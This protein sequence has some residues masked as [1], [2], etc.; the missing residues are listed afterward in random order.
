MADVRW[1]CV[2]CGASAGVDPRYLAAARAV[3]EG[4]AARG[5]GLVY[6]GGR[7]GLMG[8]VAEAALAAG[9]DVVG[10][11]P[12]GLVIRLLEASRSDRVS[13]MTLS[14]A[15]NWVSSVATFA[16]PSRIITRIA[17]SVGSAT[18]RSGLPSAREPDCTAASTS[19]RLASWITRR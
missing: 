18:E 1:I 13:A 3:G 12:Q 2:F 4:L 8:A 17:V 9:G 11:I 14:P 19:S 10:V 5:I 7:V 15:L 16:E 6:G